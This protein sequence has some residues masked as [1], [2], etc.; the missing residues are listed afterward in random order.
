MIDIR[1]VEKRAFQK[2]R[3]PNSM[4]TSYLLEFVDDEILGS[5]GA[6][7]G[8]SIASTTTIAA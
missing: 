2:L 3:S 8:S 4:F 6:N 5:I 7:T 1:S